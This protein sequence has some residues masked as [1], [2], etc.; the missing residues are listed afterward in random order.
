MVQSER[1]SSVEHLWQYSVH[2]FQYFSQVL[3]VCAVTPSAMVLHANKISHA[4]LILF[5][6]CT[7]YM[8]NSEGQKNEY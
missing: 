7:G 4:M 1:Y 2:F 3:E 8:T 6:P 5:G